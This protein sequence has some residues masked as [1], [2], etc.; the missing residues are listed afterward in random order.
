MQFKN[1]TFLNYPVVAAGVLGLRRRRQLYVVLA[2][3][4]W[5]PRRPGAGNVAENLPL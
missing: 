4:R 1:E 5:P 2:A 3:S